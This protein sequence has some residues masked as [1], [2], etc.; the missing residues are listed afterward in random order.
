M[1]TGVCIAIIGVAIS[2]V[3][4]GCA[5]YKPPMKR[6]VVT[7]REIARPYDRTW[8]NIIEWF[9]SNNIPIK[10]IDKQSGFIT[11]EFDLRNN[12]R[13]SCD[14]GKSGF[15]AIVNDQVVGNFNV[16]VRTVGDSTTRVSVKTFF[17]STTREASFSTAVPDRIVPIDCAT[18][19]YLKGLVLGS[20]GR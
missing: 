3:V 14:C 10:T 7:E 17:K 1:R 9:A 12:I 19:G 5:G 4:A 11:T 2:A 16:I 15:G 8:N 18:T 20:A 6:D 13:E